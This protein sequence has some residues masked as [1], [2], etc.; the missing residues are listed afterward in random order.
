[1][2]IQF[3]LEDLNRPAIKTLREEVKDLCQSQIIELVDYLNVDQDEAERI[4]IDKHLNQ[5]NCG[6]VIEI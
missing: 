3:S 1:M 4:V 6:F 2:K 5:N